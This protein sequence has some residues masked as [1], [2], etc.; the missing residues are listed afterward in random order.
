MNYKS[1]LK[2]LLCFVLLLTI[3]VG[4]RNNEDSHADN[5]PGSTGPGDH[6]HG[7]DRE[8]AMA[9][10]SQDT[11]MI[12][13]GDA[14]ITWAEL[15]FFLHN[16]LSHF[17]QGFMMEVDWDEEFFDNKT[18]SE[19]LLEFTT[20][21]VLELLVFE[22]ALSLLGASLSPEDL[23]MIQ[24]DIDMMVA[25]AESPE[26]LEKTLID[27]GFFNIE[28]YK[29]LRLREFIPWQLL[30]TLY[31]DDLSNISDAT[32]AD[33][34][35]EHNFM[36]AK[37][38]LLAFLREEDGYSL[39]EIDEHK[40]DL[41]VQVED[42]LAQLA[43]RAEDDDFIEFFDELMWEYSEDPGMYYEPGGY[44]FL[45]EDMV[46]PFSEAAAAIKPGEISDIVVTSYGYH[47]VLR[48][49]LNYDEVY[50]K[51]GYTLRMLA[52]INDFEEKIEYWRETMN[53]EY[54]DAYNSINLPEIFIWR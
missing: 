29:M 22:Y 12:R 35:E 17:S 46:A 34:T 39:Q 2:I 15:Y 23:D 10:F 54:T 53:V 41:R 19:S 5:G 14:V 32:I 24:T 6:V 3:V 7:L 51:Y 31:G 36:R 4:F 28:V 47:I 33:F 49:P 37:H 21:H 43:E 40:I 45:P 13:A 38:I 16:A 27:N 52:V 9:A 44:L 20:E 11:V 30:N 42:I 18:I 50:A 8:F 48:L 1:Y 26:I 25:S